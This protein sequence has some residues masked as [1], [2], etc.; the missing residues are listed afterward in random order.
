MPG[1]L[2]GSLVTPGTV[3]WAR[4]S[5]GRHRRFNLKLSQIA[6]G[7]AVTRARS[8]RVTQCT[9]WHRASDPQAQ[10]PEASAPQPGFRRRSPAGLRRRNPGPRRR[11]LS[12]KLCA[13]SRICGLNRCKKEQ[14]RIYS[15]RRRQ[16]P[17][18]KAW[19]DSVVPSRTDDPSVAEASPLMQRDLSTR[20]IRH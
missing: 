8:R 4:P 3:R 17:L 14:N 11:K 1:R 10:R 16:L 19:G 20:P 9:P 2:A 6:A 15:V 5:P 18:S 13:D 7:I 12:V